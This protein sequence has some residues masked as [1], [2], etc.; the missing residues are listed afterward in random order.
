MPLRL[1]PPPRGSRRS[2]ECRCR[3]DA[4]AQR[5]PG[6]AR[7]DSFRLGAGLRG[8]VQAGVARGV[9]GGGRAASR[10]GCGEAGLAR[11]SGYRSRHHGRDPGSGGRSNRAAVQPL[12][13]GAGRRRV[14]VG[15]AAVRGDRAR[16]RD[17]RPRH[18]RHEVEHP[19]ARRRAARLGWQATR[20]D[21]GR[22]RGHGGGRQ[23]VL[24]LSAVEA[25]S[26]RCRCDGDRRHGQ[27]PAGR[28]DAHGGVAGHGDGDG[29][30]AHAGGAEAQRPVRR[31]GAGCV[32]R[33][34]ARAGL[35]ARRERRR[36]RGGAPPRRVDGRLVHRRRVPRARRGRARSAVL[37]HRAAWGSGSGRDRR[38]R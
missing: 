37:R 25:G 18:R 10:R 8:R 31:R 13:R 24:D 23:R 21:Q 12:R 9:R 15:V 29:R 34:A 19:H 35:D 11:A 6:A 14:E 33:A 32:D 16:R 30:G 28:P 26:V 38:S 20:W 3:A 4:A 36:R 27:R 5:R 2:Q 17:L 22:D 7:R 1:R